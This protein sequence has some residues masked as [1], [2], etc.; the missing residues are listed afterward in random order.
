MG[1][2]I[3]VDYPHTK[4]IRLWKAACQDEGVRWTCN[5]IAMCAQVQILEL[6]DNDITPLG[7]EFIGRLLNPHNPSK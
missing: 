4:S 6:L 2:L 5:Y 1:A 3:D 7:C